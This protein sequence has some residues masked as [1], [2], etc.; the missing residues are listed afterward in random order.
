VAP[1]EAL[2]LLR[3]VATLPRLHLRGLMCMLPFDLPEA[4]QRRHFA[5]VRELRDRANAEGLNLDTLSMGMSGD[6]AAAVAEGATILRIGTAL[7]GARPK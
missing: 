4:E 5:R 3:T 2:P 6:L 1:D 7:F